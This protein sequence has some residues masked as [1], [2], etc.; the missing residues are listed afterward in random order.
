MRIWDIPTEKLCRKHLLG[1]H[2]EL[3]AIWSIIIQEKKGYFHHPEVS[4]WKGKLKA[5][6]MKHDEIVNEMK[7]R[8]YKHNSPLNKIYAKGKDEQDELINSISDQI[9]I[10]RNKKCKCKL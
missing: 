6:Y 4:R 8:G 7:T 5:L 3:H 2:S 1:E 10:L 9:K